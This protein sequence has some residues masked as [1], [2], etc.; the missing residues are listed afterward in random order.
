MKE[1]FVNVGT[2]I[3]NTAKG[4]LQGIKNIPG[5]VKN[6]ATVSE[7]KLEK[8]RNSVDLGRIAALKEK[9]INFITSFALKLQKT[10]VKDAKSNAEKLTKNENS[11]GLSKNSII[12]GDVEVKKNI[13][14]QSQSK[15]KGKSLDNMLNNAKAKSE[16]IDKTNQSFG[17]NSH[18]IGDKTLNRQ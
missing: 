1:F 16:A 11:L 9:V 15:S 2:G 17:M 6:F 7:N 5:H 18:S 4:L 10:L 12:R 8:K 14:S 13:Q 3:A